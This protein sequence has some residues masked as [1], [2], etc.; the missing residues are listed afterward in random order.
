MELLPG[1][2]ISLR[3]ACGAPKVKKNGRNRHG[4]WRKPTVSW[5]DSAY[6]HG[7]SHWMLEPQHHPI[8]VGL[9]MKTGWSL[10]LA[11]VIAANESGMN[12][13]IG[14]YALLTLT[15]VWAWNDRS[16]LVAAARL[17]K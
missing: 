2:L 7:L 9:K 4:R 1:D 14:G 5:P 11:I 8:L 3:D 13:M 15:R 17:M 16:L 12:V 10:P 6:A